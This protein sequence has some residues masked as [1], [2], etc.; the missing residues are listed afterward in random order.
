MWWFKTFCLLDGWKKKTTFSLLL[1]G[2]SS[3]G[4][5][6]RQCDV[7]ISVEISKN[8]TH[9]FRVLCRDDSSRAT[10]I[11]TISTNCWTRGASVEWLLLLVGQV[12]DMN[13]R[14]S[15]ERCAGPAGRF[16]RCGRRCC[17]GEKREEGQRRC[18][19][20]ESFTSILFDMTRMDP[21]RHVVQGQSTACVQDARRG[22]LKEDEDAESAREP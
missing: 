17:Q 21:A 14:H 22:V 3:V 7:R 2:T 11:P 9:A 5:G 15:M 1:V 16:Y 20:F 4:G 10:S 6:Q 13:S 8:W 19:L 12:L 18:L